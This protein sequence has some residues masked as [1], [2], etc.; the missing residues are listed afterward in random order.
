MY[1]NINMYIVSLAIYWLNLLI[2]YA[3]Y[4]AI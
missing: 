4:V 3:S 2:M 1:V